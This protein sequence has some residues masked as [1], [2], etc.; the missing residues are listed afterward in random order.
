[1][2]FVCEMST[3]Y[4][5][6]LPEV[7]IYD[8]LLLLEQYEAQ[9]AEILYQQIFKLFTIVDIKWWLKNNCT[10]WFSFYKKK[11]ISQVLF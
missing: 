1:M 9:K 8:A 6:T 2:P 5:R 3:E 4:L 7:W 11:M 10:D